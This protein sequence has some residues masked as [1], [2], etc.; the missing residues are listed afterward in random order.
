[1]V[2]SEL[3]NMCSVSVRLLE[4]KRSALDPALAC[5]K[6][7]VVFNKSLYNTLHNLTS[8]YTTHCRPVDIYRS[9][10]IITYY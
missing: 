9:E 4:L 10:L 5:I 1:M 7:R 8:W 2:I 3:S 6:T